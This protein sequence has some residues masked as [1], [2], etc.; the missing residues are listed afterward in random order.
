MISKLNHVVL[1]RFHFFSF[2]LEVQPSIV[3]FF[4]PSVGTGREDTE[5]F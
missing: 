3:I 2:R 5:F 4:G 1:K